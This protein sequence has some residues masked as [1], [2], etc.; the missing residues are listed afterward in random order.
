MK[1][2]INKRLSKK[3]SYN[4]NQRKKRAVKIERRKND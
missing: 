2:K 3:R 1:S 4:D